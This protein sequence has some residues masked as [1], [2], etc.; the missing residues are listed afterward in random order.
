VEPARGAR[1]W[2]SW[3]CDSSL[4]L[5]SATEYHDVWGRKGRPRR[6]SEFEEYRNLRTHRQAKAPTALLSPQCADFFRR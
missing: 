2:G 6:S 5:A 3:G 4:N 1:Y